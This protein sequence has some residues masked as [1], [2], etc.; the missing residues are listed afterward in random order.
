MPP[1]CRSCLQC[2]DI[3]R[4]TGF[5]DVKK[6]EQLKANHGQKYTVL[7]SEQDVGI[8]VRLSKVLYLPQGGG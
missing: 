4:I 7:N 3:E 1:P 6:Q 2:S 8:L 5:L